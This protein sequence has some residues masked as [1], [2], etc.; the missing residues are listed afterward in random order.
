MSD[1]VAAPYRNR[2]GG[3]IFF[4]LLEL[5]IGALCLLFLAFGVFAFVMASNTPGAPAL[6]PG[7]MIASLSLYLVAG[8]VLVILG[9]GSIMARR[10][11]RDLSL[12]TA[13]A[14]LIGGVVTATAMFMVVPRFLPPDQAG[15][16]AVMTCLT[17]AFA[18][19]GVAIPLALI[20]FYRSPNVRATC[21]ELDPQPRWTERV[22][23]PLLGLS[24]WMALSAVSMIAAASYAV[25]PL[26]RQ[27]IIGP[28]A[29]V[30][31]C[32]LGLILVYVSWGL[33]MRK[34]VA[35]W[36]GMAWSVITGIYGLL[37]FR[38]LDYEKLTAAMHL[39]KTPGVPDLAAIYRNPWFV[40]WI[41][42]FWAAYFGYFVF[43]R[44]YFRKT[45]PEIV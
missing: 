38:N 26:G 14:W 23:L 17:I 45:A 11:A 3:L 1:A 5:A 37:V 19:F 8:V 28:I 35:W 31:D 16:T 9:I 7:Q 32:V 13:W 10:W 20:L 44:R 43:V 22:P 36:T 29:V 33:Y 21:L 15:M 24:M 42:V 2:R 25:L 4:G 40:G 18:L 39:P 12:I 6:R 27:I 41:A 30:V 34:L